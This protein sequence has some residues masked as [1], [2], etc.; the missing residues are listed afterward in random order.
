MRKIFLLAGL[1]LAAANGYAGSTDSLKVES[2]VSVENS[3]RENIT[4]S[5]N[6]F[7]VEI[8]CK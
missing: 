3:E 1:L 7:N 5:D 6:R 8:D 2:V 4:E